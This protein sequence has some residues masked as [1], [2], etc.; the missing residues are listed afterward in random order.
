MNHDR[1]NSR[2]NAAFMGNVAECYQTVQYVRVV[3][4]QA[5]GVEE[6]ADLSV[7]H[8]AAAFEAFAQDGG[9]NDIARL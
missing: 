6:H 4:N 1:F 5:R 2:V 9:S 7:A 8:Y 3:S